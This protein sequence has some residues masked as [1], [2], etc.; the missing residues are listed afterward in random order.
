MQAYQAALGAITAHSGIPED[1]ILDLRGNHDAFSV[2]ERC[3]LHYACMHWQLNVGD[4]L[5]ADMSRIPV[6]AGP[7]DFFPIYSATGRRNGTARVYSHALHAAHR[8]HHTQVD[9][10]PD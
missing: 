5:M 4:A 7:G 8:A 9:I 6:R 1:S 3:L 10:L 2:P